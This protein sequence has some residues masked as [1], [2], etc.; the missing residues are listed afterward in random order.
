L[1]L[2]FFALSTDYKKNQL[3]EIL[4]LITKGFTYG[5]VL[6]MPIFVRRYYINF[7]IEKQTE[8]S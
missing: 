8:N 1:G 4:Y 5:D 3:D 6:T 2:T 7:L